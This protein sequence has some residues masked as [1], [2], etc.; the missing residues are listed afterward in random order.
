VAQQTDL[1]PYGSVGIDLKPIGLDI[2]MANYIGKKLG[3]TVEL[4]LLAKD[5]SSFIGV[6]D[7]AGKLKAK[8]NEIL[9]GARKAGDLPR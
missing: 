8:V 6:A 3:V 7:G 4:V 1:A 2:D 9:V 5:G